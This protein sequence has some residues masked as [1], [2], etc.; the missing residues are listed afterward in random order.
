MGIFG[1]TIFTN[2]MPALK[3]ELEEGEN[4][5]KPTIVEE[6]GIGWRK[7]KVF[8]LGGKVGW[9]VDNGTIRGAVT[10]GGVGGKG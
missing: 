6:D 10:F 4:T 7:E 9:V 5:G 3:K 1:L 8:I 2:R